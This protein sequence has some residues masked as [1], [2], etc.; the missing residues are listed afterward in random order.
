[1]CS[2][3]VRCLALRVFIGF[4]SC[5]LFEVNDL[6]TTRKNII[7]YYGVDSPCMLYDLMFFPS[8]SILILCF[9]RFNN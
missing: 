5:I 2:V 1:M 6:L 7:L 4:K 9:R 8:L 3:A